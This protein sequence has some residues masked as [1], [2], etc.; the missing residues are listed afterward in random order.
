MRAP[1]RP[2]KAT[3]FR[4]TLRAGR[5][6]DWK[7]NP[8]SPLG[9]ANPS[10]WHNSSGGAV[11]VHPVEGMTFDQFV[12]TIEIA[13]YP[14]IESRD[15]VRNPSP[16]ATGPHWHVVLG[17]R[18]GGD[19]SA[20]EPA[21]RSP[22]P[23]TGKVTS[24]ASLPKPPPMSAIEAGALGAVDG[25]TFGFGDELGAVADS[26][27]GGGKATV[28][29]GH[30]FGDAYSANVEANRER[31]QA[32]QSDHPL[33]YGGGGLAGAFVPVAGA[34]GGAL[35]AATAMAKLKSAA[36]TGAAYGA[37]Y[38]LGSDEGSPLERMDGAAMGA[39]IGAVGGVALHGAASGVKA[40]GTPLLRKFL[41]RIEESI[42]ARMQADTYSVSNPF[43]AISYL[44]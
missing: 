19:D 38:G 40:V 3:A 11:D 44:C 36:K 41:P 26:V 4:S 1:A 5:L 43:A 23:E 9:R 25:L 22:A 13:G 6:T 18:S 21:P 7:R 16:H 34:A 24:P 2:K 29:D 33:A 28:W 42:F 32:A 14:V 12:K 39:G 27:L 20:S 10:S 8:E 30:S 31:L 35:K 37:I 17:Q 15:E